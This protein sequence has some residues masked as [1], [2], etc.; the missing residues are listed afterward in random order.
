MSQSALRA[1]SLWHRD[2]VRGVGTGGL[3]PRH[4]TQFRIE[5]R[6]ASQCQAT[7]RPRSR[8]GSQVR[9]AGGGPR[10]PLQVHR[11]CAVDLRRRRTSAFGAVHIL[12]F[13]VDD[14]IEVTSE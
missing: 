1:L 4:P 3:R 9:A 8:V 6:L 5:G 12:R 2:M 10:W 11:C 13:H 14:G 7:G